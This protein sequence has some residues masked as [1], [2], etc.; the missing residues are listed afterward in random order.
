MSA[1]T[2]T[3]HG[4]TRFWAVRDGGGDLICVCV[5]K[6]GAIEVARRLTSAPPLGDCYLRETP[7][8]SAREPVRAL[9]KAACQ[10][11]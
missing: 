10:G 7:P 6:R 8:E 11:D 2:V 4:R 3:K 1:V 9:S 5:Y